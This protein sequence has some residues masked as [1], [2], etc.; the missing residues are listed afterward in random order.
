[1]HT[2]LAHILAHNFYILIPLYRLY[3]I[4]KLS[5]IINFKGL[6]LFLIFI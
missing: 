4:L 6:I 3:I 2:I 1:M 5:N